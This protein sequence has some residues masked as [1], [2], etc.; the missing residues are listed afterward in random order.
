MQRQ[1]T[2]LLGLAITLAVAY[3]AFA[4][5][6][7]AGNKPKRAKPPVWS[8]RSKQ[9]FFEDARQALVGERP[10]YG[11]G[12][13]GVASSGGSGG[14]TDSGGDAGGTYT[15]SQLISAETIEDEVKS[16]AEGINRTVTNPQQYAGGAYKV[17]QDHF[18]VLAVMFGIIG[19]YDADVRWKKN[20]IAA[21]EEFAAAGF[22]SRVGSIQAFNQAKASKEDLGNLLN[23][24]S[25]P[26][27]EAEAKAKWD[28][29]AYR[30]P[31]MRRL[32][33]AQ[34]E[35]LK[36]WTA[37]PGEFKKNAEKIKHEAEIVAALADVI[38]RE[39]F[40]FADDSTY[41][42]HCKTLKKSALDVL[43][44]VKQSNADGA[45]T[46]MGVMGKTCTA[47]HEGFRS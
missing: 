1:A 14:A 2:F 24:Q 3:C 42:E 37:S 28:K 21:R 43:E 46:A 29:V 39:G 45:R 15:W 34:E 20:A 12:S 5:D 6:P 9:A 25:L 31:L 13:G 4:D 27:K 36:G 22:G 32:K 47:C 30:P 38:G 16:A 26:A 19:E 8:E 7:P 10:K 18:S 35:K 23:G 44:A 11:G 17:G 41:A 33:I 40:E